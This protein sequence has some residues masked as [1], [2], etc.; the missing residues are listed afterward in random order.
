MTQRD[1]LGSPN[2]GTCVLCPALGQRN[3]QCGEEGRADVCR[4]LAV[5]MPIVKMSG[6]C[7][8]GGEGNAG[9]AVTLPEST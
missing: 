2:T 9:W 7:A 6:G 4:I 5:S 8:K 1:Q 3:S